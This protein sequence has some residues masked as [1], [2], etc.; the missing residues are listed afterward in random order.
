MRFRIVYSNIVCV[1]C[2]FAVYISESRLQNGPWNVVNKQSVSVLTIKSKSVALRLPTL[3]RNWLIFT[4]KAP[5]FKNP[6]VLSLTTPLSSFYKIINYM[7]L[8]STIYHKKRRFVHKK[9]LMR[10]YNYEVIRKQIWPLSFIIGLH[11][12]QRWI[13]YSWKDKYV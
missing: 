12:L 8:Y 3:Y 9:F 2:I 10:I 4:C 7:S 5:F 1:H 6:K 13:V 11:A